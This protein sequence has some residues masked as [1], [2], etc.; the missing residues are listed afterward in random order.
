[1]KAEREI[2]IEEEP[3][4]PQPEPYT[5]NDLHLALLKKQRTYLSKTDSKGRGS[6]GGSAIKKYNELTVT[7]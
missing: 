1:M 4:S 2:P 5:E 7:I 3:D 6:N